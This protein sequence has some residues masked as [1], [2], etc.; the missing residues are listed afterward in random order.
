MNDEKEWLDVVHEVNL[1][2]DHNKTSAQKII[3]YCNNEKNYNLIDI[4]F[5]EI[6]NGL[7]KIAV[8]TSNADR[9]NSYSRALSDLVELAQ[10]DMRLGQFLIK[11]AM[12]QLC[13]TG[14][15]IEKR[16]KKWEIKFPKID[17]NLQKFDIS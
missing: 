16:G 2:L 4:E 5:V 12:N 15:N 10:R 9:I 13:S 7:S 17:I 8:L 3:G 14:F 1:I 6:L 11:H